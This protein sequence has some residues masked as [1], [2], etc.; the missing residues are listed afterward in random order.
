MGSQ[1]F[2]RVRYCIQDRKYVEFFLLSQC[3][4][5]YGEC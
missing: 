5:L 1:V 2:L 3:I 4:L